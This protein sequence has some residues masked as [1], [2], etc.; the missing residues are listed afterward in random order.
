MKTYRS[1]TPL[2]TEAI[3]KS[4]REAAV[5]IFASLLLAIGLNLFLV[6]QQLLSGGV[7]GVASIIGYIW[8]INISAIYFFLNIPLVIWG[9][10]IVGKRY[11]VLSLLS[12]LSTSWFLA[13]IPVYQVAKDPIMSS[14]AGGIITACGIGFALRA[15]GS[16]GGFDIIG[17]IVTRTRDVPLGTILFVLNGLVILLLGFYKNWDLALYS[18]LS[19]FIKGKVV[20]MIHVGHVKV[21]CFIITKETDRMLDKLKRLPHGITCLESKGGYSN[22]QNS[23]L[24]TVTTRYELTALRKAMLEADPKAFMNV[25][26]S[27]EIVGRFSRPSK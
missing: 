15:G 19:T 9:W 10:K 24:M 20:D 13:I 1:S 18:M 8:D 2:S 25:V 27:S 3:I 21:T 6:P 14:V 23:M 5:M 22:E 16:T 17:S 26:N 11:I 12:V 7:T 4:I